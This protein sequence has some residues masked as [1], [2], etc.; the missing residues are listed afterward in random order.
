[1]DRDKICCNAMPVVVKETGESK[2]LCTYFSN[3]EEGKYE[4]CVDEYC[5]ECAGYVSRKEWY[6]KRLKEK[7]QNERNKV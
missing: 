6:E 2:R 7:E 1:M 5:E 3:D 4:Y